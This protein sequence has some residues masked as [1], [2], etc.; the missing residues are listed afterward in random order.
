MA[1]PTTYHGV[2]AVPSPGTL[3]VPRDGEVLVWWAAVEEISPTAHESMHADLDEDTLGRINA[4]VREDDRRRGVVAHGLLRR[5][6]AATTGIAPADVRIRRVCANCG[7]GD[8]GK[9]E[10]ITA[11]ARPPLQFNLAHSGGIVAVALAGPGTDVGIDVEAFRHEFDWLPA[12]R[13]VFTDDEWNRSVAADHPSTERFTLWARKEA[14]A[15]TTGHGLAID[16]V[17]VQIDDVAPSL[18]ELD[19][20]VTEEARRARLLAPERTYDLRVSDFDVDGTAAGAVATHARPGVPAPHVTV[21]RAA[22]G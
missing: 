17:H 14:A 10:L 6:V 8:H 1:P 18:G 7:P 2:R 12:R 4:L 19:A 5:L 13:H 3:P 21:V 11:G 20:D 16:L 22:L 9:P 15:K